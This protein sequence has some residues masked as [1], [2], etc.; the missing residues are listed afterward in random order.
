MPDPAVGGPDLIFAGAQRRGLAL[1][2]GC[3]HLRLGRVIGRLSFIQARLGEN[4]LLHQGTDPVQGRRG[5]A[6][7]GFGRGDIG[8]EDRQ[9]QGPLTLA[10]V[11]G[12][13]LG[14]ANLG[15]GLIALSLEL[16][17]VDDE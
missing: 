17:R 2:F 12:L 1:A 14:R 9:L 11:G 16:R 15:A 10:G 13:G 5:V 3:F 4:A 7:G 8:V 6:R